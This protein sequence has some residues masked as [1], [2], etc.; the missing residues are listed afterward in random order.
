MTTRERFFSQNEWTENISRTDLDRTWHTMRTQKK[1]RWKEHQ[2]YKKDHPE[3]PCAT[4]T[5]VPGIKNATENRW[6]RKES[7]YLPEKERESWILWTVSLRENKGMRTQLE[8]S[9]WWSVRELDE[10]QSNI[11]PNLFL[12]THPI[13]RRSYA[14]TAAFRLI[15][16]STGSW[17]WRCSLSLF[18][19]WNDVLIREI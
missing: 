14:G 2:E 15:P 5:S 16:C 7:M 8:W 1:R 13:R 12:N 11:L 10:R 3:K 6:W 17:C 9:S 18:F 19:W 4:N